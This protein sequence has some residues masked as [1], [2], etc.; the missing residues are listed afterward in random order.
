LDVPGNG[1]IIAGGST[2]NP[3]DATVPSLTG[4][5]Q[6]GSGT[7]LTQYKW[8]YGDVD[9]QAAQ[10]G[11]TITSVLNTGGQINAIVAASWQ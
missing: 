8:V 11:R 7:I 9:H 2:Q 4:I 6:A 3:P 10:T 1:V 5:T